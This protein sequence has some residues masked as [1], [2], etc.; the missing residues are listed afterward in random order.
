MR[1]V[2]LYI[3]GKNGNA[4]EANHFKTI[5]NKY[6]ILG[7]DYKSATPWETKNEFLTAY[8]K[9]MKKYAGVTIIANS[10]GAYFAMNALQSRN[11]QQ[12]LFLSPIVN[13]EKIISDMMHR[14]GITERELED[15]QEINTAFG[16]KLSWKYLTYVREHRIL[17]NI[18]THILYGEKDD[19][20]D[21]GT[22]HAF[23]DK[24]HATLTIMKNG[25]HWFHT[26]EE[27]IFL[28]NWIKMYLR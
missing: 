28:D 24:H 11:I 17:W 27:M 5:C 19:L 3:H 2:I 13:M 25:N 10:I 12:A 7:L 9:L 26:E 4:N 21:Y 8:E 22:I 18:P 23:A 16:E 20:I 1:K 15:K 14:A 6:S